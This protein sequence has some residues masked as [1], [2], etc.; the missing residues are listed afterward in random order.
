MSP[1]ETERKA[2]ETH[3]ELAPEA[4][5]PPSFSLA[6]SR[7]PFSHGV[8]RRQAFFVPSNAIMAPALGVFA[9]PYPPPGP[10]LSHQ[11]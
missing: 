3:Q 8:L 1:V 10:A 7:G 4:L 11:I 9:A 2:P 5:A 6:P